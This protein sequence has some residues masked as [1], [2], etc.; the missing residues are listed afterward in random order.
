MADAL[1]VPGA[2]WVVDDHADSTSLQG[3]SACSS[4]SGYLLRV[5]EPRPGRHPDS[6]LLRRVARRYGL[7]ARQVGVFTALLAAVPFVACSSSHD[8]TG[9]PLAKGAGAADDGV[10][11]TAGGQKGNGGFGGVPPGGNSG[12]SAGI[13][14]GGNAG[15]PSSPPPDCMPSADESGCVGQVY[16]GETLPLDIY[17]MFDQS[18]SMSTVEQGGVTRIDAVRSAMGK[19]LRDRASAGLSVGIGYFGQEPIGETTCNPADYAKADVAI[20]P[21]PANAQAIADSLASRQ[22]T[23]E[24]PTGSAIRGACGYAKNYKIAHPDRDVVMLF[25]TDGL[26]EAPVTCGDAGKGACCP[27]LS[28][29]VAATSDCLAGMPALKTFVLGVGPYLTNLQ[30]IAAAGGTKQAFLVN[31]GDVAAEVLDALNAIRTAAQIPCELG[32]PEPPSGMSLDLTLVNLVETTIR[33]DSTTLVYRESVSSCGT[34]GGWYFDDP[35]APKKIVL[36]KKSCD[37]VSL[38][39]EKLLFSLGCARRSIR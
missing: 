12:A 25:V 19:F 27:T 8:S 2:T 34:A 9:T 36:C 4:L 13:L 6:N 18:G 16:A 32:I 1:M 3:S 28:D 20:A 35:N 23:G 30:Q 14:D 21:L 22:P 11:F 33:C 39:G 7:A 17:V 26:P 38:P 29:A 10:I 37:D 24:T 15:F 31:G 5:I